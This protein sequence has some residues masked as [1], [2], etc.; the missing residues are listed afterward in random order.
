MRIVFFGTPDFSATL[1]TFLIDQGV[2]IAAVVTRPDKPQGRSSKPQ[3]SAVKKLALQKNLPLYQPPKAS[4]PLFAEELKK[5]HA[6]LFVVAAYAEILKEN[7]LSITPLGCI[8]VHASILPKYRGAAPI[9]RAIMTGER[10]GGI[11]IMKMVLELDAG[12][13]YSVAKTPI[14]ETMTT[15]ELTAHFAVIGGPAL[16]QVM[17]DLEKGT[18][19]PIPQDSSQATYAK[20]ITTEDAQINWNHSS[21]QIDCQIRGVTPNPG[22]WCWIELRGEKKRLLI[23]KAQKILE[24]YELLLSQPGEI[25]SS[26]PSRLIIS[27]GEG[28]LEIFELQLEGKQSM[29]TSN[30]LKGISKKQIVFLK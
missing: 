24:S 26:E 18:A 17:Q 27:C 16:W 28:A 12:D 10:E 25:V 13:M 14:T 22:A 11:T 4:D 2:D 7:I 8:N 15:G 20:K 3:F 21:W 29:T 19:R 23:K 9:Q 6:D 30:F 5:L 1:L